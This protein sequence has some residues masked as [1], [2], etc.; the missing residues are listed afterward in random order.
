MGEGACP[1]GARSEIVP[2]PTFK[3][4]RQVGH[5]YKI[6]ENNLMV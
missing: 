2:A 4:L 1:Y 5:F 3:I 6:S